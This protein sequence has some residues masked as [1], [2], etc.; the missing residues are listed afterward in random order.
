MSAL[1]TPQLRELQAEISGELSEREKGEL[2]QTRQQIFELVNLKGF[3]VRKLVLEA[4]AR[5]QRKNGKAPVRYRN[6]D[7]SALTWTGR[8]RK[9][10]WLVE[11]LAT[12]R[13]LDDFKV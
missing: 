11:L 9:P 12:G 7:N 4:Q 2:A 3:A 5:G 8:G 6:P 10:V 1:T 13:Y